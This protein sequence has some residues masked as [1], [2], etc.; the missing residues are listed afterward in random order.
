[1][2]DRIQHNGA[3][4]SSLQHLDDSYY[5]RLQ[6]LQAY[7]R[8]QFTEIFDYFE[9]K[10]KVKVK[11]PELVNRMN[12][13]LDSSDG[14]LKFM[15]KMGKMTKGKISRTPI[16]LSKGSS[17][18]RALI[19]DFHTKY[20][21]SGTY[22]RLHKLKQQYFILKAF[23]A[24]KEVIEKCFHCKRFNSRPVKVNTNDYKEWHANPPQR[25]FSH[26]FVD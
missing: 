5:C 13:I 6:L 1:M 18:T 4:I 24:V 23:S 25:C 10:C 26:C 7:Q 19:W 12:I 21:H 20:N 3:R 8:L 11:I 16:L 2:T 9:S 14:L 15:S 17:Y 22:Y